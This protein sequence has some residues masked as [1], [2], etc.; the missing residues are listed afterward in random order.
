MLDSKFGQMALKVGD[1]AVTLADGAMNTG[2]VKVSTRVVKDTYLNRVE[3]A[4]RAVKKSVSSAYAGLAMPVAKTYV[5]VLELADSSVEYM[6]PTDEATDASVASTATPTDTRLMSKEQCRSVVG[7]GRK[8][9]RRAASRVAGVRKKLAGVRA[10]LGKQAALVL[11]QSKPANLKKTASMMASKSLAAI[12]KMGL[13]IKKG[14]HHFKR[15]CHA[16]YQLAAE[17]LVKLGNLKGKAMSSIQLKLQPVAAA[18]RARGQVAVKMADGWLL[19]YTYTAAVRNTGVRL[20]T[21]KV[22]PVV[23]RCRLAA[24]GLGQAPP[25]R[26][27]HTT[28][29][30]PVPPIKLS[31]VTA[32]ANPV[33]SMPAP[34]TPAPAP[35]PPQKRDEKSA[36]IMEEAKLAESA[37]EESS[38]AAATGAGQGDKGDEVAEAGEAN[39]EG[40][41]A[42]SDSKKS[43][44]SATVGVLACVW[45][46]AG[47]MRGDAGRVMCGHVRSCQYLGCDEAKILSHRSQDTVRRN[48]GTALHSCPSHWR[49]GVGASMPSWQHAQ[50]GTARAQLQLCDA[51]CVASRCWAGGAS[52][53][54]HG[55]GRAALGCRLPYGSGCRQGHLS[56]LGDFRA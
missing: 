49:R 36:G 13:A 52:R 7:V 41:A 35:A 55:R 31:S 39:Q 21:T 23:S 4:S 45:R 53:K 16:A 33:T 56:R 43:K 46:A 12:Q 25:S 3:P 42:K 24:G 20:Y 40:L 37:E 47:A 2:V 19:K 34:R 44:V 10:R 29:P 48:E 15:A 50:L 32:A 22:A 51:R 9:V 17:R 6:L 30:A 11:E 14:P 28:V 8:A 5:W 27:V 18:M 1:R 26:K 38:A 54:L